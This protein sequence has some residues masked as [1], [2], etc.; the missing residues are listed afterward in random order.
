M[1]SEGL[2]ARGGATASY[3]AARRSWVARDKPGH[4]EQGEGLKAGIH[5]NAG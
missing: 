3:P 5:L 2:G 1:I 4:D